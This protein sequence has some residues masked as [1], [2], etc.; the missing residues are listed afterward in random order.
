MRPARFFLPLSTFLL[1]LGAGFYIYLQHF[2]QV[3]KHNF[4]SFDFYLSAILTIFGF[5]LIAGT[6][7][8]RQTLTVL[9]AFILFVVSLYEIF[10][11]SGQLQSLSFLSLLLFGMIAFLFVCRGNKAK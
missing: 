10:T 5:L 1:R 3:L 4:Q 7:A 6:F 8:K 11:F 2:N 9:S